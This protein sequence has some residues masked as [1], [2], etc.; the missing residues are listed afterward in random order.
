MADQKELFRPDL[1][2]ADF[3]EKPGERANRAAAER[4]RRRRQSGTAAT[5][6]GDVAGVVDGTKGV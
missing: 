5:V 3:E 4:S 1:D 2:V 6:R